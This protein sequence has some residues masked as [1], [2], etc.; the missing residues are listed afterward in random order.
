MYYRLFDW[1]LTHPQLANNAIRA[2]KMGLSWSVGCN[3]DIV[4]YCQLFLMAEMIEVCLLLSIA[5]VG[6]PMTSNASLTCIY[7]KLGSNLKLWNS[8]SVRTHGNFFHFLFFSASTHI[9]FYVI[10]S[11][12]TPY[13]IYGSFYQFIYNNSLP[14]QPI[15]FPKSQ[16]RKKK[17]KPLRTSCIPRK[18][19]LLCL[20]IT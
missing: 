11:R 16:S 14:P 8:W 18:M 19:R 2:E 1:P 5:W 3:V 13:I 17:H 7:E 12:G 6:P 10:T 15:S 20:I 4:L 9:S